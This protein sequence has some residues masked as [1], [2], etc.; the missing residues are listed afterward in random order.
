M[1][2]KLEEIKKMINTESEKKTKSTTIITKG[3]EKKEGKSNQK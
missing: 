2:E 1:D 3:E